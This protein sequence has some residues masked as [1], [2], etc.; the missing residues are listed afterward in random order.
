MQSNAVTD[1][2]TLYYKEG[3]SDKIYEVSV[4]SSGTGFV[5]NFA[6]GRRGSTLQTGTKTPAP[7]EYSA[8]KNG[9]RQACA[10]EDGQGLYPRRRWHA[11]PADGQRGPGHRRVAPVAQLDHGR[12]GRDAHCGPSL[13]GSGEVR[14]ASHPDP[15]ARPGGPRHQ[16]HRAAGELA[17][18]G[19][20]SRAGDAG[21]RRVACSTAR[22]WATSTTSLTRWSGMEWTCGCGRMPSVTRTRWTWPTAASPTACCMPRWRR[23]TPPSG[24]C[25]S[26]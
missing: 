13:V 9:L 12:G 3:S 1:T 5:V 2:V 16:P 14:W 22:P 20:R 24:R 6:F 21:G 26:S 23:R 7:L 19:G 4:E 18:A 10:G 25:S 15:K 11:V 8:A 17:R